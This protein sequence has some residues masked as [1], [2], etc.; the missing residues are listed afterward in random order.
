MFPGSRQQPTQHGRVG[1]PGGIDPLGA[2]NMKD[3]EIRFGPDVQNAHVN[4]MIL[5]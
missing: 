3:V 5:L 2:G 1:N 4:R